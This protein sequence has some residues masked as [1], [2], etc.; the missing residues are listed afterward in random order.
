MAGWRDLRPTKH[1]RIEMGQ[2]QILTKTTERDR[3]AQCIVQMKGTQTVLIPPAG[4]H[5][6][7]PGARKG[8]VSKDSGPKVFNFDRSYWSFDKSDPSY[9]AYSTRLL[10]FGIAGQVG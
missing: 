9:G 5:T 7:N 1:Q 3:G 10:V 2:K 6:E 4:H 8:T